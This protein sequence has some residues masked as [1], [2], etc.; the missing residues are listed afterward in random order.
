[1][2]CSN[3]R[4]INKL[5]PT[6]EADSLKEEEASTPGSTAGIPCSSSE[7]DGWTSSAAPQSAKEKIKRY[8]YDLIRKNQYQD[9]YCKKI[10]SSTIGGALS[11]SLSSSEASSKVASMDG[12]KSSESS[13]K[14]ATC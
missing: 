9:L 5:F 14:S 4:V 13:G 11:A 10:H 8:E 7:E 1:M 12:S 3:G 2:S 6:E